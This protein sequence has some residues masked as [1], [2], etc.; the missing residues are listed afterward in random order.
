MGVSDEALWAARWSDGRYSVFFAPA[1]SGKA[2]DLAAQ[3][4]ECT[5]DGWPGRAARRIA[6]L[7]VKFLELGVTSRRNWNA[8]KSGRVRIAGREIFWSGPHEQFASRS[9]IPARVAGKPRAKRDARPCPTRL[10]SCIHL[11]HELVIF[12]APDFDEACGWAERV[13]HVEHSSA[14]CEAVERVEVQLAPSLEGHAPI[15]YRVWI[16]GCKVGWPEPEFG[17]AEPQPPLPPIAAEARLAIP[18][19]DEVAPDPPVWLPPLKVGEV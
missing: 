17:L 5:A 18:Q 2:R 6:L 14:D 11:K 1:D 13:L 10:W 16:D 3:R 15:C 7:P 19:Y 4:Q 8:P 9:F 12:N